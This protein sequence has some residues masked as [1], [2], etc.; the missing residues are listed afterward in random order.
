[1]QIDFRWKQLKLTMRL[2]III[3]QIAVIQRQIA[4]IP[5]IILIQIDRRKHRINSTKP[6]IQTV[7]MA[8]QWIEKALDLLRSE[9][10]IWRNNNHNNYNMKAFGKLNFRYSCVWIFFCM[11]KSHSFLQ[12]SCSL[13][14]H[15]D[16]FVYISYF[17]LK[18]VSRL[19]CK[20]CIH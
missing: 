7:R 8:F 10:F 14:L 19:R 1:M 11:S 3:G 12:I 20:T 15:S 5:L 2:P 17:F 18:E 13:L 6:N 16:P 4:K 9:H